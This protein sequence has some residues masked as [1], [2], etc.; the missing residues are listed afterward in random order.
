M[1]VLLGLITCLLFTAW[2]IAAVAS[3]RLRA[4]GLHVLVWRWLTGE[5]H[6]GKPQTNRGWRRPAT[7]ALTPTG[8]ARHWYWLPRSQHALYRSGLTAVTVLLGAGLLSQRSR[9][10][11]YLTITGC[12]AAAYGAWRAVTAARLRHH[13]RNYVKPLHARLTHLVPVPLPA[14]PES[15]LEVPPD[16]SYAALTM[17]RGM[18]LP[19]PAEQTAIEAAAAATLGM[20]NAR[21]TWRKA[22]PQMQLRLVAPVPPPRWVGLDHLEWDGR[23][24]PGVPPDV[25]RQAILTAEVHEF[26]LGVGEDGHVVKISR[27]HDS[28]HIIVSVDSGG[29]KSV[30]VRCLLPQMLLRGGIAAVL[31][32]KLVSHPSLR[33]LPNVAYCDDIPKIHDF[34][35]WLDGELNRRARFVRDHTDVYGRLTGSPGPPL[36]VVL[37]EQNLTMNRLRSYW[38]ELRAADKTLP[39]DQRQNLPAVS[40]AIRGFENASYAGRELQIIL[41]FVAQRFTAEAAGG[42]AK[43]AAVRLNAGT[44]LLGGY[45]AAT[46]DMLVGR[47]VPMPPPSR[48]PGRMQLY[49]KGRNDPVEVQ[50]AFFTHQQARQL[51]E[52]GDQRVPAPLRRFTVFGTVPQVPPPAAVGGATGGDGVTAPAPAIPPPPGPPVRNVMTIRQAA[53]AGLLPASWTRPGGAFRTA[54]HRAAKRGV[55]VPRVVAMKGSEALYDAVELADFLEQISQAH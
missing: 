10:L 52:T 1:P 41:A 21:P 37:E 15:W 20:R 43:G 25:I 39:P 28:P 50:V 7:R 49:V 54:K 44:R 14:R 2:G 27:T 30:L 46:W 38:D 36:L 17:P 12:A 34:L 42:G 22:G 18:P 35:V 16:R 48:H 19:S 45:D 32:S 3:K 53:D 6:H 23:A 11:A 5:A 31:D 26:V 13:R 40:P 51:A 55:P 4:H 33:G 9:T 8:H 47:H 29:G 24:A